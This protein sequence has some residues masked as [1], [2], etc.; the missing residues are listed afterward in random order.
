M[1]TRKTDPYSSE[2]F[3]YI[4]DERAISSSC[5]W[6]AAG[7]WFSLGTPVSSTKKTHCHDI[8]EILLK[9]ALN[10]ITPFICFNWVIKE[11]S[12]LLI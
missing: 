8:S 6:L 4:G 5:Q 3:F 1:G 2:F 10:T 11:L 7:Q 9:V 12:P